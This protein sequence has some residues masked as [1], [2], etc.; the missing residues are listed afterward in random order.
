MDLRY[1]SYKSGSE[2]NRANDYLLNLVRDFVHVYAVVVSHLLV[3]AIPTLESK[4]I[5]RDVAAYCDKSL[6][7]TY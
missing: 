1:S 3:I 4:T 7:C 6:K 5:E 2:G